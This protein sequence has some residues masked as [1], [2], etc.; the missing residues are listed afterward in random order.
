MTYKFRVAELTSD[1]ITLDATSSGTKFGAV[2]A[3]TQAGSG[4]RLSITFHIA[5]EGDVERDAEPAA[6][7]GLR[8]SPDSAELR[9]ATGCIE[10]DVV[11]RKLGDP[12]LV[13]H[14]AAQLL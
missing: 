3:V 2:W 8:D 4:S 10:G 6:A 1:H 13:G 14:L 9:A 7:A 12:E 5:L 11:R